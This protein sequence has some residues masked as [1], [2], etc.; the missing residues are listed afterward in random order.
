VVGRLRKLCFLRGGGACLLPQDK[1]PRRLG[2]K[3]TS[4]LGLLVAGLLSIAAPAAAQHRDL[5]RTQPLRYYQVS[6]GLTLAGFGLSGLAYLAFRDSP[7]G[8]RWNSFHADDLVERNFSAAAAAVSD[9]LLITNLAL[10]LAVQMSHGVDVTVANAGLIYGQTQSL[11]SLL[12]MTAKLAARRPRPYTQSA[13]PRV[14]DF[15]RNVGPDSTMS[16]FSGHASASFSAATTGSILY[17]ARS[18]LEWARYTYFGFG[19]TLAGV[20]AQLRVCAGRHYRSDIWTG[21]LVGLGMGV[22][23]PWLNDVDLSRV[24]TSEVAV[25]GAATAVTMGLSEA[26][27][28][29]G[30]MSRLGLRDVPRK[31]LAPVEVPGES[32]G[33]MPPPKVPE[34]RAPG[35]WFVL[36]AIFVDGFGLQLSGEL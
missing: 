2:L 3:N 5:H 35:S 34:T 24:R 31:L 23:V 29:C 25:A 22:L 7:H 6:G 36:P 4:L 10:P 13:D 14:R 27:G 33:G 26:V 9:Q 8:S 12:V 20:T 30:L 19:Y 18:E 28:F 21:A 11:N 17:A 15:A 16:F 1:E 32:E